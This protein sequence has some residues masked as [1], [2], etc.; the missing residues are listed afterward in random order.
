MA[1]ADI[2]SYQVLLRFQNYA[3]SKCALVISGL[4]DFRIADKPL[5]STMLEEQSEAPSP[6]A[7]GFIVMTGRSAWSQPG[8]LSLCIVIRSRTARINTNPLPDP[9]RLRCTKNLLGEDCKTVHTPDHC[10][11][12]LHATGD[13][14]GGPPPQ[15]LLGALVVV[16]A[17]CRR[18]VNRTILALGRRRGPGRMVST[19]R[20]HLMAKVQRRRRIKAC[21]PTTGRWARLI[22]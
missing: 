15:L 1:A 10:S 2:T 16:P 22:E 21:L 19:D 8:S 7:L 14:A 12:R 17:K 6:V 18:P 3:D 20:D 9:T 5:A 11:T 4:L 13:R